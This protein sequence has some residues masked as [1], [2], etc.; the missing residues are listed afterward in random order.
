[1]LGD[2]YVWTSALTV[3]RCKEL[4]SRCNELNE[5]QAVTGLDNT[6]DLSL[7][8]SKVSWVPRPG[9][10]DLYG[11]IESYT[12]R[13]NRDFFSFDI[14]HGVHEVQ[15]AKYDSK[16]L[17]HYGWHE[18]VFYKSSKPYDRKLSLI[19]QLS[20][21]DDY[22][23][24]DFEFRGCDLIESEQI[25]PQGSVLVFPS[26]QQHRVSEVTKGLRYSITTWIEGPKW[27]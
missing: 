14:S 21:P 3:E 19:I 11:Y 16:Q 12:S 25:R 4:I 13:V 20:N 9:F 15:F 8:R 18:D 17:G 23:G 6:P 24:G 7:R 5:M 26:F 22:E 2:W 27:K 1:M 10:E